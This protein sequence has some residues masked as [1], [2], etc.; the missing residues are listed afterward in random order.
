MNGTKITGRPES[1]STPS[2]TTSSG[3]DFSRS[4]W[5]TTTRSKRRPSR[6]SCVGGAGNAGGDDAALERDA[7]ALGGL[8]EAADRVARPLVRF[9]ALRL[10]E[11]RRN[12]AHHRARDDRL[13]GKRDAEHMGFEHAPRRDREIAGGIVGAQAEIDDN[14]LDHGKSPDRASLPAA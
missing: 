1:N 2:S 6:P 11:F 13:I 14:I 5:P 7:G 3:T 4:G 12:A 10:D 8:L 9:R